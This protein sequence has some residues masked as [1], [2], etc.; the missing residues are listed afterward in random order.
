MRQMGSRYRGG[1]TTSS[2]TG[3]AISITCIGEAAKEEIVYRNGAKETDLH[4]C[5]GRLGRCLY[6]TST[7]GTRKG[8]I[9]RTDRRYPKEDG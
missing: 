2:L 9:L 8:C 5:V 4:L 3:L 7:A 6:G 1:D